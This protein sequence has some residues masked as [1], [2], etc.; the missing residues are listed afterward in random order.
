MRPLT[1]LF[2][3][4]LLAGCGNHNAEATPL[5]ESPPP[6]ATSATFVDAAATCGPV[7]LPDCPLQGWMKANALRALS[8]GDLPRLEKAFDRIATFDASEYPNWGSI[9]A[10]GKH[11][12]ADGDL[13]AARRAC[14]QCHDEYRSAYRETRRTRPIR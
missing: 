6:I 14:K 2:L 8:T 4:G 3:S 12:A 5:E 9:A 13:E 7:G 1:F 10:D 11:A